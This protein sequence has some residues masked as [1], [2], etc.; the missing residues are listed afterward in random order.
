LGQ[1]WRHPKV[2]SRPPQQSEVKT[3][4][5]FNFD[6]EISRAGSGS[7]KFDARQA[8]FGKA[9]VQPLWVADMDFAAPEAL[10]KA[11]EKRAAHPVYGY[12]LAPES[13]F[14]ALM[15]W[16]EK[17]HGWQVERDWI[18][19]CPGVVPSLNATVLALTQPG[20]AVVVQPPVYFPFFSA[21]TAT[22]RRLVEN[23]LRLENGCYTMDRY[24]MDFDHLE[25]CAAEGARLLLLCSP[26]NP[27]GRVWQPQELDTLGQI[28]QRHGMTILSDEIHADLVYPGHRHTPLATR[29]GMEHLTITAVAP[30]KTFNIPG[31]GLSVLIV[32]DP[33]RR[34]ALHKAF[35]TLHVST[36]N[37]F[38][39]TAFEA[40]YREG[41]AWLDALLLYLQGTHDCVRDT[42][43]DHLP[44][45]DLIAPEG[46]YLL[47]L[48]CQKM[49]MDDRQLQRFLVE[50]A[51]LGLSPGTLFGT[52]GSGF[53]RMN[54]GTPRSN[55]LSALQKL[56]GALDGR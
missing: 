54:I 48:D 38:S 51:G 47:W 18:M 34:T 13:L 21:V 29:P 33:I 39:L 3:V 46:T 42:L 23:P 41:E 16:L 7:L 53:M 24:T 49:G 30:S 19:L 4:L 25:R 8:V 35:D 43:L 2:V 12:T 27:V 50:R 32:P 22:G 52:G 31:L 45:I 37:P 28:A 5:N 26:H 14:E 56:R 1:N 17:R 40:A 44:Q 10:V 15:A 6:Q 55:I 20:D 36:G 9:E 11:L